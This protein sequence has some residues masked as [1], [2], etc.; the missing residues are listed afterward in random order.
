MR[1]GVGVQNVALGVGF[2]GVGKRKKAGVDDVDFLGGLHWPDMVLEWFCWRRKIEAMTRNCDGD[3]I[4]PFV[5]IMQENR[6]VWRD[7]RKIQP[8]QIEARPSTG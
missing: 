1:R 6:N 4:F 3:A 2:D 8:R 7:F 5:V